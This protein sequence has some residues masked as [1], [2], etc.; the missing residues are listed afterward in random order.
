MCRLKMF[1]GVAAILA[2][3]R[4]M[5]GQ[6]DGHGYTL[7]PP[8]P[9]S[10]QPGYQVI[11][12]VPEII[13]PQIQ[14]LE[15]GHFD[16]GTIDKLTKLPEYFKISIPA[17]IRS[18]RFV[19]TTYP[20]SDNAEQ[21]RPFAKQF[22]E[23]GS[24]AIPYLIQAIDDRNSVL[25]DSVILI[26]TEMK[27]PP[28]AALPAL[29]NK[30]NRISADP[31]KVNY[32]GMPATLYALGKFGPVNLEV[33]PALVTALIESADQAEA[34][35]ALGQIGPAASST[36]P[37][38][39]K[40][41]GAESFV[42]DPTPYR[43]RIM[44]A[45]R[46]IGPGATAAAPLLLH[47][48]YSPTLTGPP[49]WK[50]NQEDSRYIRLDAALALIDIGGCPFADLPQLYRCLARGN[51][52]FEKIVAGSENVVVALTR[53]LNCKDQAVQ[54]IALYNIIDIG[55]S[56]RSLVEPLKK[57]LLDDNV[58]LLG[59]TAGAMTSIGPTAIPTLI[60]VL[61]NSKKSQSRKYAA[62][63]LFNLGP[64]A[65]PALPAL[66]L[67]RLDTAS[68]STVE[69]APKGIG[70]NQEVSFC[71]ALRIVSETD[72]LV[73]AMCAESELDTQALVDYWT[74]SDEV[75]KRA[76]EAVLSLPK[77]KTTATVFLRSQ[78]ATGADTTSAKAIL[79]KVEPT[80][81]DWVHENS[82]QM[83]F[84]ALILVAISLA[85]YCRR[86]LSS[87]KPAK[88]NCE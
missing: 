48:M 16:I 40:A 79:S 50:P 46:R 53:A 13:R 24:A 44:R 63:G 55:P 78:I 45:L 8:E 83:I 2:F 41:Y 58:K 32:V 25:A 26:L 74:N 11:E 23:F 5:L 65:A 4:V 27:P 21:M 35:D 17:A 49:F 31:L 39:I 52:R 38:L 18:L 30:A 7:Y 59:M 73:K 84:C 12:E 33:I 9:P 47:E 54:E 22:S 81:A 82:R 6:P 60:D 1:T 88:A 10:M 72:P 51:D 66:V 75:G 71:E 28:T 14:A 68:S 80:F 64:N 67:F 70:K 56:A 29:V 15:T 19:T 57:Q 34:I 37:A 3:S 43:R 77:I 61:L 76:V 86:R 69:I 85:F 20:P 42:G 62:V 36:V 87:H